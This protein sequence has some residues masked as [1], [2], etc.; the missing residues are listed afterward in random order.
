MLSV[1]EDLGGPLEWVAVVHRNTEHP[2]VHVALRG[3][4][5]DGKALRLSRDYV[6]RG[7]REIAE[8]LCTRQLGFRTSLDAAEAERRETAQPRLTSL[9]RV[10]LRDSAPVEKGLVFKP[11]VERGRAG[12]QY[13]SA[14]LIALA[15]MGLAERKSDDSWLLRSDTERVLRAMQRAADRQKTLRAHG[16]LVSDRRL[17]VEVADWQ[18]VPSV[19]GR[20]LVHGEEE[21]SGKNYLLLESTAAKVYYIPY[22][23]EIEETRSRGG[24]RPNS[25]VRLRRQSGN[26]RPGIEIEDL[27]HAEQ[28]LGNRLMLREKAEELRQ[29]GTHPTEAGW[30]GWLGRYQRALCEVEAER[31]FPGRSQQIDRERHRRDRGFER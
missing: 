22:T 24:L 11:P 10:I 17:T 31:S 5:A 23:R 6:K 16:E 1:K 9:D 3:V 20:V 8:D 4:A 21:Y 27:G 18:R 14:R 19:E 12:N 30:G 7:V 26:G 25:F 29:H 13:V 15:R 2:H 28:V